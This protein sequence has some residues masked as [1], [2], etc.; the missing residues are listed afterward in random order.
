M[1]Q[2][3]LTLSLIL[4]AA[5][6]PARCAQAGLG[7]AASAIDD[8]A[9]RLRASHDTQMRA[10]FTVHEL[11][12]PEGVRIREFLAPSG[13]VF[14]LAWQG[15]FRPDLRTLLG[16]HFQSYSAAPRSAGSTRSRMKIEQPDLVVLSAGHMHSF[17]GLAYRPGSL[18]AGVSV[19]EL[20]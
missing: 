19:E 15:P 10:G 12:T 8:E 13:T 9:L 18:P 1:L 4:A 6:A 2:L 14:A 5:L 16:K 3:I 11:R 17:R 20:Q 7:D